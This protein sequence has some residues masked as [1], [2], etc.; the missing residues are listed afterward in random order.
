MAKYKFGIAVAVS[1]SKI[2]DENLA[3]S[4]LFSDEVTKL[5]EIHD[6]ESASVAYNEGLEYFCHAD[7]IVFAHQ[8]VYLPKNWRDDIVRAVDELNDNNKRW[9]VLGVFGKTSRGMPVGRLWDSG[10]S[11]EYGEEFQ[12]PIEVQTLDELLL[13]VNPKS[14]IH[15]DEKLPGFHMF[16]TDI[17]ASARANG[18]ACYV[19]HAPVVHNSKRIRSLGGDYLRAYKYIRKKWAKQLPLYS[20]CGKVSNWG[21]EFQ[22]I[23]FGLSYRRWLGLLSKRPAGSDDPISVARKLGYE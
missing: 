19:V 12:N 15:F 22:R 20:V 8:D 1:N 3:K 13:I 17:C 14:K 11:I 4:P 21:L 23:R 6:A 9:A 16:G 5:L 7:F 10:M 18:Y 2:L